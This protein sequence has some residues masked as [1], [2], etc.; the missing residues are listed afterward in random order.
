MRQAMV[1]VNSNIGG[2]RD[3]PGGRERSA[4]ARRHEI[5]YLGTESPA[6]PEVYSTNCGLTRNQI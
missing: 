3:W 1:F 5:F 4:G 6:Q 2:G